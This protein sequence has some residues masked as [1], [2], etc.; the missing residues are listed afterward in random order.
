MADEAVA[1][2][3]S[4][5]S[6]QAVA[7]SFREEM[8]EGTQFNIPESEV[9]ESEVTVAPPGRP[10]NRLVETEMTQC[11][12]ISQTLALAEES[13]WLVLFHLFVAP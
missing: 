5:M 10:F 12:S 6:E 11:E 9:A 8:P 2:I 4:Q 1:C 3:L 7:G 13:E